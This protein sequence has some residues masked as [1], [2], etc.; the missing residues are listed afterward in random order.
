MSDRQLTLI[1]GTIFMILTWLQ[2]SATTVAM[3][4]LRGTPPF[5]DCATENFPINLSAIQWLKQDQF[6]SLSQIG[7]QMI[8]RLTKHY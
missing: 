6:A 3:S 8:Y 5:S 4:H 2:F 7:S 1:L